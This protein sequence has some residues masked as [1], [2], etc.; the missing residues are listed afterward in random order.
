MRTMYFNVLCKKN[1]FQNL[2]VE[3]LHKDHKLF[4]ESKNNI[5]RII[6]ICPIPIKCLCQSRLVFC[7]IYNQMIITTESKYL[8]NK[9]L[10]V[11][12][13]QFY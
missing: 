2:K 7:L 6:L 8:N 3:M 10:P 11:Y 9:N 5:Y 4:S 13:F 12:L 1:P